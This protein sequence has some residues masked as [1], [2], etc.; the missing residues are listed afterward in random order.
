[1][2][3]LKSSIPY[4]KALFQLAKEKNELADV[5]ADANLILESLKG[6]AEFG[7]MISN[8]TISKSNKT[9]ILQ[10]LFSSKIKSETNSFLALLVNKGRISEL[11][12]VCEAFID[13]VNKESNTVKVRLT[14]AYKISDDTQK[15][16]AGK[17]MGESKYEI[18]NI[19]NPDILGGYI[20]EFNNKMLDQSISNKIQTIKNNIDK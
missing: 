9:E 12:S 5:K 13:M 17:A 19:I 7:N 1:M 10:K 20:L 4:A 16:I 11:D 3:V 8:P 15:Q 6:S 18:E 2:A 14:T